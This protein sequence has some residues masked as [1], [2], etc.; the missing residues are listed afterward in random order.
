MTLMAAWFVDSL[1][2]RMVASSREASSMMAVSFQD[3][4]V[5]LKVIASASVE[6]V[7]R[8]RGRTSP[9]VMIPLSEASSMAFWADF[10]LVITKAREDVVLPAAPRIV[11]F[12]RAVALD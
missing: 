1:E 3:S 8:A 2:S 10:A 12:D 9:A 5:S 11:A 4:S 6:L 7:A